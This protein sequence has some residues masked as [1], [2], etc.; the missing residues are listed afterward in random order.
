MNRLLLIL[1]LLSAG[2]CNRENAPDCLRSAG[3]DDAELRETGA[4]RS[5]ELRDFMRIELVDD[6]SWYVEL[7][8]PRNLLEGIRT[9]VVDGKLHV[10]NRNTC[11]FVRSYRRRVTVRIHAPSFPDIQN[12]GTG[13][14]VALNTLAAPFFKLENRDAAGNI[15][16]RVTADS[17]HVLSHTG[18]ADVTLSGQCGELR[19]FSQGLGWLDARGLQAEAAYVNNSSINE[20]YVRAS[21]YLYAFIRYSGNIHVYGNPQQV[22][23]E[24]EGSGQLIYP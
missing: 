3:P 1:I 16:L 17:V 6:E 24:T 10:S 22:D 14:L 15:D 8:G 9:E 4:F 2:S 23:H 11:N 5:I 19:L 20:V 21:G 7:E 12:Y 13:D 18:V